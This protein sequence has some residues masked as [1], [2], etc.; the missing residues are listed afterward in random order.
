MTNVTG[1]G[2]GGG[3]GGRCSCVDPPRK[4]FT[5]QTNNSAPMMTRM[6]CRHLF[7]HDPRLMS[8]GDV[9]TELDPRRYESYEY[10]SLAP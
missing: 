9:T 2:C 5:T 4:R 6:S 7:L 8:V 10:I 1:L 3:G